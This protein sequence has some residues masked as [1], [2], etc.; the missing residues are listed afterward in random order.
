MILDLA[1]AV[2]RGLAGW[3]LEVSERCC[4]CRECRR[5]RDAVSS[6]LAAH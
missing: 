3:L 1:H 2:L 6:R 5:R 4:G